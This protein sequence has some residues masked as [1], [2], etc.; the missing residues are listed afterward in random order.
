MHAHHPLVSE[1]ELSNHLS[2]FITK[3]FIFP[4]DIN[5]FYAN[6]WAHK[7]SFYPALTSDTFIR[8]TC[9]MY[10]KLHSFLKFFPILTISTEFYLK[11]FTG[12]QQLFP[13]HMQCL[14]WLFR[15]FFKFYMLCRDIWLSNTPNLNINNSFSFCWWEKGE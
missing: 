12:V 2:P 4:S 15:F 6:F 10:V 5:E 8:F 14:A 11:Y 9:L 13:M 1:L 3:Q 7:T